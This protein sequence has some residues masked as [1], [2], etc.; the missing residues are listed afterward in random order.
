VPLAEFFLA[1]TCRE[2]GAG[3]K[4][5]SPETAEALD[6]YPWPGNIRELEN[7]VARA[8]ALSDDDSLTPPTCASA[9]PSRKARSPRPIRRG[10]VPRIRA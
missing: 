5:L 1:R 10:A 7:A 8:V 4:T 6:R 3:R 9:W 2:L